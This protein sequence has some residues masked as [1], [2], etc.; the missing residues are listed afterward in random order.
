M[1]Y[2]LLLANL[3]G[4][5][6]CQQISGTLFRHSLQADDTAGRTFFVPSFTIIRFE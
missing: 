5:R 3:N 1:E 4:L 2:P 6:A